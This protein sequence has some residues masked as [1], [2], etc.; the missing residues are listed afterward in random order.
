MARL[1]EPERTPVAH[2]H[3]G[4][5]GLR[6]QCGMVVLRPKCDIV[7]SADR[8]VLTVAVWRGCTLTL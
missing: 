8:T 3:I 2:L 1:T 4:M 7:G 6:P 5:V